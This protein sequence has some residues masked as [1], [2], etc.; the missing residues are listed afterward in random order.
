MLVAPKK[1]TQSGW[2]KLLLLAAA[3]ALLTG[4]A[5]AQ[6]AQTEMSPLVP[7]ISLGKEQKRSLTPEEQERQKKIDE[8][9]RAATKKI[10]EQKA[11]DPWADVRPAPTTSAPKK[12]VQ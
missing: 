8:D 1:L 12:K 11:N 7:G 3:L 10:P 9:Y 4:S 6:P 5:S 2:S